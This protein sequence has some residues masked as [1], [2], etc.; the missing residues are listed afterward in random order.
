MPQR[1]LWASTGT[2]NPA[3]PDML[4]LDTLIGTDTVNTVPPKTMDAFRDHG[5]VGRDARPPM[6]MRRGMSWPRPS[7]SGSIS[8][9]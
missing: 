6:S 4:Y 1:L 7:G 2:K 8:T 5:T 3:Y 9:A